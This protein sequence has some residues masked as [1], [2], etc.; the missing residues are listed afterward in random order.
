MTDFE[1]ALQL[2]VKKL[3]LQNAK[4]KKLATT[5]GFF[6]VYFET[7]KDSKT[8]QEAF[9]IVNEQ[10]YSLFGKYRYADYSS[11]KNI[12]TYYHKKSKK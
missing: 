9:N 2:E 6:K 10:Y 4:M 11:F 8:N 5:E 1:N 12:T 7:C 3:E